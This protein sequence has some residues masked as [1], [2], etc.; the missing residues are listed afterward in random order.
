MLRAH[1]PLLL[2][3][4]AAVLLFAL[5]LWRY[6][7]DGN[8]APAARAPSEMVSGKADVHVA[9]RVAPAQEI[10]AKGSAPVATRQDVARWIAESEGAD[11][12]KRAAAIAA[13][14][15]APRADA[16]PTLRRIIINGEPLVDRPLALRS[17]RD[18]AL[19]QGDSDGAIRDAV[20]E[21]IYH[22]DDQS[23]TADVQ[24]VLDTIEESQLR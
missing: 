5:V 12:G 16:L 8:E 1:K 6:G 9:E 23:P 21:V 15:G 2:T 24:E 20:R 4:G 17:L 13:L 10:A 11:A 14:G 3:L 19:S 22:G 18:L 7:R